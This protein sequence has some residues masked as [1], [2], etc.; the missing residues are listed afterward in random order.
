VSYFA[1]LVEEAF[2]VALAGSPFP[3]GGSD[4]AGGAPGGFPAGAGRGG[5]QDEVG[6]IEGSVGQC[7]CALRAPSAPSVSSP[8]VLLLAAYIL[9]RSSRARRGALLRNS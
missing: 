6:A 4:G 2:A 8:F 5:E 9:R 7:G 3:Q 1:P